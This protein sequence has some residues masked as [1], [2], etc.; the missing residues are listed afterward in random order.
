MCN[1][2]KDQAIFVS[3]FSYGS[4]IFIDKKT[5]NSEHITQWKCVQTA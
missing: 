1:E 5:M 2:R 4:N 3:T